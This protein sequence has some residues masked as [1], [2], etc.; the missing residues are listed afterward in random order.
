M[1]YLMDDNRPWFKSISGWNKK[2]TLRDEAFCAHAILDEELFIKVSSKTLMGLC[3]L[4]F[5]TMELV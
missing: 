3:E 4:V 5:K 2:D 1:I